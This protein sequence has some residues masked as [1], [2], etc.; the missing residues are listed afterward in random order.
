MGAWE[1]W[2][3]FFLIGV[4]E[5]ANQAFEAATRIVALFKDDRERIQAESDRAG[6]ALRLHEKLQAHP[7]ATSG[8]L[9][10]RTGL[11]TPTVNAALVDLERLGVVEEVTGRKRGRVFG[12]RCYLDILGEGTEPLATD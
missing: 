12:Y 11:S 1:D 10:E 4:A 7:F 2:L 5:T 9:V 6:S 8:Q 3:A